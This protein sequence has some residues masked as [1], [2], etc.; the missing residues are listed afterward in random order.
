MYFPWEMFRFCSAIRDSDMSYE[1]RS[2]IR[3]AMLSKD[4]NS[5]SLVAALWFL[6][7]VFSPPWTSRR[8]FLTRR[9]TEFKTPPPWSSEYVGR[10]YLERVEVRLVCWKERWF[11]CFCNCSVQVRLLRA[12]PVEMVVRQGWV[13]VYMWCFWC[14]TGFK[15][16]NGPLVALFDLWSISRN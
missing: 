11:Q 3:A 4:W 14:C 13:P 2:L 10:Y 6:S 16:L 8:S 1:W 9:A 7:V 5:S 12:T 15:G